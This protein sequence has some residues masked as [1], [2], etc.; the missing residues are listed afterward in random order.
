MVAVTAQKDVFQDLANTVN[1]PIKVGKQLWCRR[2]NQVTTR[3]STLHKM[4]KGFPV[5]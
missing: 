5:A 2:T 4:V 3:R 1:L